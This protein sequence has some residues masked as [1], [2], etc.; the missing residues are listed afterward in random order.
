VYDLI[1][2]SNVSNNTHRFVEKLNL[3]SQ[4][5]PVR[6]NEDE[7]FMASNE[8][9]LVVPTYGG[10]NENTTIP[11]QVK[12]FLSFKTNRDLLRGVVGMGNT[13]FGD[14]YCR[15]AEMIAAK[16]GVPLLYRVEIMGTPDDVEQVKE[17]LET[18]WR[19]TA[20]TN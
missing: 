12:K 6:W 20:T 19:I 17:R 2:F 13:N 7:P 15:A 3:P 4:R 10:G 11:V 18:L 5:I 8:Y 14:H 9:V 1:Y 16:I